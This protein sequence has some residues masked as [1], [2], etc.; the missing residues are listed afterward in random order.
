MK[1][2]TAIIGYGR[3]GSTMHADPVEKWDDFEMVSV[4]DIDPIAREKASNRFNCP[5][6]ENYLEMLEKEDIDL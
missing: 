5:T 6:Y 2:K 1:I 3:N 4:C